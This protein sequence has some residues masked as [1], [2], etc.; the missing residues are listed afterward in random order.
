MSRAG[1]SENLASKVIRRSVAVDNLACKD[2]TMPAMKKKRTRRPAKAR[3]EALLAQFRQEFAQSGA[4][5][6]AKALSAERRSEI[7]KHA[8]LSYWGSKKKKKRSKRR[9]GQKR[10]RK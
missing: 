10:G 9:A 2:Y 7:A 5:A 6:R 1:K 4:R 8:S 3:R